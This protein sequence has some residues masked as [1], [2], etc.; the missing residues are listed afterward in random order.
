MHEHLYDPTSRQYPQRK[1]DKRENS[2]Y[3]LLAKCK[4]LSLVRL[5]SPRGSVERLLLPRMSFSRR[6]KFSTSFGISCSSFVS[7][8]KIRSCVKWP[9]ALGRKGSLNCEEQQCVQRDKDRFYE[10]FRTK[11]LPD[12]RTVV[13]S[14]LQ[15]ILKCNSFSAFN[16]LLRAFFQI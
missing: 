5:L 1:V 2:S 6:H 14:G 11:V 3:L 15:S 10:I 16:Q 13:T 7:S 8:T 12:Q 9:T 4:L